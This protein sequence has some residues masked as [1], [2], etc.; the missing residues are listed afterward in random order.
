MKIENVILGYKEMQLT[1]SL[2]IVGLAI[3]GAATLEMAL[4]YGG[5]K[6]SKN[7]FTSILSKCVQGIEGE[8]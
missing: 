5:Y 7:L 2:G 4:L 3:I 6:L 8:V 1:V